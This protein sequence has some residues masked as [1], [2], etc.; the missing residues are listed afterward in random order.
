MF[1]FCAALDAIDPVCGQA[2]WEGQRCG[3]PLGHA[4]RAHRPVDPAVAAVVDRVAQDASRAAKSGK[5]PFEL[6]DLQ[7]VGAM[8]RQLGT[9]LVKAG[10]VADG[11]RDLDPATYLPLYR[12][13]L[14]RHV[15]GAEQSDVDP[16]TGESHYAGIAVNAMICAV[17]ER[18]LAERSIVHDTQ[19]TLPDEGFERPSKARRASD[20]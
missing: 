18:T 9:G 1:F 15:V 13:A 4:E 10:R 3:L 8:A 16:E 11:W 7:F 14:L 19:L 6:V 20:A 12:A 5:T 2:M 17:F